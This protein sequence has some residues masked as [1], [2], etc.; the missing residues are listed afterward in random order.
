MNSPNFEDVI[1]K[2]NRIHEWIIHAYK[3]SN[4]ITPGDITWTKNYLDLAINLITN[5]EKEIT[6][7][8]K[9]IKNME[10]LL[11]R[12]N[13]SNENLDRERKII[14]REN[15]RLMNEKRCLQ[16]TLQATQQEL[17][18]KYTPP[19]FWGQGAKEIEN[20]QRDI[21]NLKRENAELHKKVAVQNIE[22]TDLIA[23]IANF[24]RDGT[25]TSTSNSRPPH[26]LLVNEFRH[27]EEQDFHFV[28]ILIFRYGY[29]KG[30]FLKENRKH[31]IARI[32]SVLSKELLNKGLEFVDN[33][34][35]PTLIKNAICRFFKII[36]DNP[37]SRDI[38]K[39]LEKLIAKG[40]ALVNQIALADPP[41]QLVI[42]K[43][44]TR[45]NPERHKAELG[46]EEGGTISF[47]VYPG[48]LVGNRV[49]EKAIV[50]TKQ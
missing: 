13:Q 46:C 36:N 7:K 42:E 30:I 11:D 2:L 1:E 16:A 38:I 31:D 48:Y 20:K 19:S 33:Q 3:R 37:S 28:S 24:K 23:T 40:L 17:T 15:E 44:G 29:Q 6:N 50:F 12:K 18:K 39:E 47:T 35:E 49:F 43:E 5:Q 27:L 34:R 26:H 22:I 4:P 25:I 8:A 9:E 14:Q 32:K 21:E 45:F 41:G 10:K